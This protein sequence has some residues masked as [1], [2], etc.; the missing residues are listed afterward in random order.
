MRFAKY[1]GLG[2]D[3]ILVD[4]RN[5]QKVA[6]QPWPEDEDVVRAL[7]DRHFGVGADGVLPILPAQSDGAHARMRV[8]NADGGEAEMC[9]NGL[10]CVVKYLYDRDADLRRERLVIDTG[11]GA[12]ACNVTAEG[13]TARTVTVD[14]GRPRLERAEIPM[15]GPAQEHCL[16]QPLDVGGRSMKITAV[17]MGNP[18]AIDFVDETGAELRALA[19][20]IGPLVE[21]HDWFPRKT[22][23]EF[24]RMHSPTDIELL[25]WERGVGIT[26]ACGTGACAT[27]V[28][29]CKTGR[30]K[31]GTE[32]SVRLLGGPLAITVAE[33]YSTV[34]MRGPAS[35]VFDASADLPRALA[36]TR[37]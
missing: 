26:H 35:H 29:A 4:L 17:S 34:F 33:D 16:E 31:P 12:L 14:M 13:D 2:N 7:C 32:I 27:A 11:A 5:E 36:A 24:A 28:A 20:S 30:A 8:L 18:H 19:E 9:G 25:V 37:P 15:T 1:H 3:F 21:V 22:N 6:G 23:V 10:R